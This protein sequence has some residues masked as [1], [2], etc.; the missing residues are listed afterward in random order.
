MD[1]MVTEGSLDRPG[2][3]ARWQQDDYRIHPA[4]TTP[5][6]AD[7]V[8]IVDTGDQLESPAVDHP[9]TFDET[10]MSLIGQPT[11]EES[12]TPHEGGVT[13]RGV[14]WAGDD[15]VSGVAVSDDGGETWHDATLFGPDYAGAWR[16]FEYDWEPAPGTHTLASRATDEHGRV[17]PASIGTPEDGLDAIENGQFP[18]NG[19][20]YAAN[21]YLPNAIEVELTNEGDTK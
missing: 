9:Y 19:G 3:H 16:L 4:G 17:Q 5:E 11:G 7:T 8:P 2:T 20:G 15:E 14:A 21:A 13:V 18:W 10:V 12:V 6:H 1:G